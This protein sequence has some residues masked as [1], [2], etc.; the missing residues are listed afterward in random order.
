MAISHYE[1]GGAEGAA[2]ETLSTKLLKRAGVDQE[3]AVQVCVCI[4]SFDCDT[5]CVYTVSVHTDTHTKKYA[6][7]Y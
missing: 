7:S 3:F 4:N 1:K 6:V 5:A 2:G